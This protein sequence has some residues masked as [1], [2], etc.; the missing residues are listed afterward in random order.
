MEKESLIQTLVGALLSRSKE[1]RTQCERHLK[2]LE[3]HEGFTA[4]LLDLLTESDEVAKLPA[5]IVFR[6]NIQKNWVSR[7]G[8]QKILPGEKT[9][10]KT[11]LIETLFH[12]KDDYKLRAQLRL[13]L[14]TIMN[15]E[16]WPEI[17]DIIK[18]LLSDPANN[19]HAYVGLLVLFE[20]AKCY[21][22]SDKIPNEGANPVLESIATDIFPYVENVAKS[23]LTQDSILSD[24][25]LYMVLKI[26]KYTTYSDIPLYL[27]NNPT[28]L[29]NWCQLHLN[30]INAPLPKIVIE[31]DP[32]E[33]CLH[34][35]VKAVKHAFGNL[36]RM[37]RSHAASAYLRKKDTKFAQIYINSFVPDIVNNYY[38]IIERW[39]TK[40]VWLSEASIF[41]LINFFDLLLDNEGWNLIKDQLDAIIRLLIVPTLSAN[42]ESIE[43]YEDDPEEYI[44]RYLDIG[45]LLTTADVGAD[46]FIYS[47][48]LKKFDQ[49]VNLLLAVVSEIFNKRGG[50]RGDLEVA[51]QTEA[52]IHIL[53]TISPNLEK[54]TSPVRGQL[55][56]IA[57]TYIV[58]E[59]LQD[60]I[61]STPWLTARACDFF[62][63]AAINYTNEAVVQD[64][65][66]GIVFC[67][68]QNDHLP[69]QIKA[70]DGLG[71]LVVEPF[72][73][74]QVGPQAPQLMNT[75]LE[76][77]KK[78]ES[79]I[80][81]EVM[82]II[83]ENFPSNLEPY[84]N[85]LSAN[86]VSQFMKLATEILENSS[87][88]GFANDYSL[89]TRNEV[90]SEKEDQAIGVLGTLSTLV[91]S[92]SHNPEVASNLAHGL[93]GVLE[94]ILESA[95]VDFLA[96]ATEI[97]ELL[98]DTSKNVLPVMWELYEICLASFQ[99]YG[100]DFFDCFELFFEAIINYGF[101]REDMKMDS[102]QV[103]GLFEICL[104]VLGPGDDTV[105]SD[106][107]EIAFSL[108]E[109]SI[110]A[111]GERFRPAVPELMSQI[112][113][114]FKN[115]ENENLFD[116]EVLDHL[117][118]SR[119]F[120][121]CIYVDAVSTLQVLS[122]KDF[123]PTFFK[124]W[125][126][127][128][129]DFRSVHGCKLQI[130]ASGAIIF[131]PA[132]LSCVPKD[133]VSETVDL[134]LDNLEAL[135][136]AIKA[137]NALFSDDDP[138]VLEDIEAVYGEN[139]AELE[140]RK[141]TPL[142]KIDA[143]S[144]AVQS[145]ISL[146]ANDSQ[147]FQ[148]IFGYLSDKQKDFLQRIIYEQQHRS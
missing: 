99:T 52:A 89:S 92:M 114:I 102:P 131:N 85:E 54:E 18:R 3:S 122:S 53:S 72:V 127:D 51:K 56:K 61:S 16:K 96:N 57:H 147:H 41:Y 49:S 148:A 11:K 29:G 33:R 140:A 63:C 74:A 77:S 68:Q 124:L 59:L 100:F 45:R 117:L 19:N 97:M 62:A 70:F 1:Q 12:V 115:M 38:K 14:S 116:G 81:N 43:M 143:A 130:L 21:R 112:F 9:A 90:E 88:S 34:P 30:V 98:V 36:R 28:N 113:D 145:I 55:D 69:I 132:A 66:H 10:I 8:T 24:E 23:L 37:L 86:L 65:F 50:N 138:R 76:L 26:Y 144:T 15:H 94:F 84:A 142:E 105:A 91:R 87:T 79:E 82:D 141:V 146:Q 119:I 134:L 7:D 75:L 48:S 135:P 58:P 101:T 73:A 120:F 60:T 95:T 13:A 44:R 64:V 2:E 93:K 125:I 83:V 35:R 4:Y 25:M 80:L 126:K 20:Y 5:A 104:K 106:E 139:D 121:A 32:S 109:L 136:G 47:L 107:A 129:S 123:L 108:L 22:W 137:R 128:S 39:S 46:N 27:V 67:S 110:L 17:E 133:Y 71:Q 118:V 40:Q 42:E 103:R 78:F 31:V 6:V 111:L